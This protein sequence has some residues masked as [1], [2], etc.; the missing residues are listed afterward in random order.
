[1]HS[2]LAAKPPS[3]HECLVVLGW[4]RW[5]EEGQEKGTVY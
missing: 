2:S 4:I 5:E 3:S 1:M